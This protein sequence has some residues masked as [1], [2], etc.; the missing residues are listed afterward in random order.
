MYVIVS[1]NHDRKNDCK[2]Q[3]IQTVGVVLNAGVDNL[4]EMQLLLYFMKY[5]INQM[6]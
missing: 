5:N 1:G 3:T 4:F 6:L 2:L